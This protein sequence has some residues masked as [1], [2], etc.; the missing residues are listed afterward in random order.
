MTNKLQV[1]LESAIPENAVTATITCKSTPGAKALL[2]RFDVDQSPAVLNGLGG[3][4][5]V[6]VSQNRKL[7]LER[8]DG[9][10]WDLVRTVRTRSIVLIQSCPVVS[11][12]SILLPDAKD[13]IRHQAYGVFLFVR[14]DKRERRPE[15]P[16]I[17][18][19]LV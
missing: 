9:A 16:H 19:G 14:H 3:Q 13:P 1:N 8:L 18:L 7:Y 12:R 10:D 15:A 6:N 11:G 2:H 4:I 17:S 5:E